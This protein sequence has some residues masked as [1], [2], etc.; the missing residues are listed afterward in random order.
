M[1]RVGLFA[2]LLLLVGLSTAFAASFSVEAE[3]VA[4]FATDVSISV[5]APTPFPSLI[6]VR[7]Q[8][9]GGT[10][11]LDLVPPS[12][13]DSVTNKLLVLSTEAIEAQT[14]AAKHFVWRAPAAPTNGYLLA[15]GV[16]LF[17]DQRDGGANLLTAGLFSCPA[18]APLT[19]VTSGT[20]ACTLIKAAVGAAGANGN[21]YQERTVLFGTIPATVIPAGSEL[22]LK[23][24]NRAADGSV[25]LSASNVEIQWG[26][27]AARQ[28]RLVISP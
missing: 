21:G 18:G 4:S 13:N 11:T 25:V 1:R 23:L 5:P 3:D 7:G 12:A 27:L 22:R 28:S 20:L 26:Y 24:V 16:S 15:G 19:T 9:S 10:G 17:I 14:D 8:A 2:A 6:Y